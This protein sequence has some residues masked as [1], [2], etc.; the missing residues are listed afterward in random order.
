M[1]KNVKRDTLYVFPE[2]DGRG[3]G[4]AACTRE[5]NMIKVRKTRERI[6]LHAYVLV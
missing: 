2:A 4:T 3:T 5:K 1:N 6:T